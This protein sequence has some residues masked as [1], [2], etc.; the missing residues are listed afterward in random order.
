MLIKA[1]GAA[2]FRFSNEDE[3]QAGVAEVL[4]GAGVTF[5]R[6]VAI[7][8]GDRLEKRIKEIEGA[9]GAKAGPT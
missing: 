8:P 5:E 6:E 2:R 7:G 1:L 4:T 9:I 3:L